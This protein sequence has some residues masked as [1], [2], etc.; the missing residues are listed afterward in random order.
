MNNQNSFEPPATNRGVVNTLI[1]Q[2]FG[3]N[4]IKMCID[5]LQATIFN[6]YSSPYMFFKEFFGIES[7]YV[8]CEEKDYMVMMFV[9]LIKT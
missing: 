2:K 4:G 8:L 6:F 7:F 5:W 3:Q 1:S 9:I